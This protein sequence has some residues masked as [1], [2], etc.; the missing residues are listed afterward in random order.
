MLTVQLCIYPFIH[1]KHRKMSGEN[2]H[3]QKALEIAQA[4]REGVT[5]PDYQESVDETI[6]QIEERLNEI[7]Q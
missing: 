7:N 4:Y 6:L 3:I 1:L 5:D 2:I